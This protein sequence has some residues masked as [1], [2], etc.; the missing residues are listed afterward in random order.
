M[1]ELRPLPGLAGGALS[2]SKE[3]EKAVGGS[4]GGGH[5]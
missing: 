3:A 5:G 4:E 2:K 1:E